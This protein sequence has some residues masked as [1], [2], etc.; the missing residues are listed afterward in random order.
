MRDVYAGLLSLEGDP[1]DSFLV[2]ARQV[3]TWAF[4][5]YDLVVSQPMSPSGSEAPVTGV[6]IQWK[7][8]QHPERPAAL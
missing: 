6:T 8:L 4:E 2:S 7:T 5:R 3:L 1:F